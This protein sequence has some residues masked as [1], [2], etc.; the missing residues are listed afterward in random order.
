[1]SD[2]ESEA[3]AAYWRFFDGC[4][5]RDSRVFT[6]TLN[7]PHV[8]VSARGWAGIVPDAET[9]A[10][11]NSFEGMLAT[12][13][14]HTVGVEP[15]VLHVAP[16]KVHLLGGWTRYTEDDRPIV[17][18]LVTYIATNV[19]GR[20]GMQSRFGIDQDLDGPTPDPCVSDEVGKVDFASNARKAEDVVAA[21]L[22]LAGADNPACAGHFQYP[23]LVI[24]PGRV[25]AYTGSADLVR[26]L[27]E[28]PLHVRTIRALHAGPTG[29]TVALEAKWSGRPVRGIC[30]VRIEHGD[31]RIKS[32]SFVRSNEPITGVGTESLSAGVPPS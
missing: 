23:Y 20:W 7:F 21:A 9:H 10:R 19:A 30:L 6:G 3:L 32:G 29:A 15:Q 18:N 2:P 22:A 5:S 11:N 12:G 8:R 26:R 16:N 4:N 24:L 28:T 27:P 31:W 14:D 17:S 25:E 13:W 1:M